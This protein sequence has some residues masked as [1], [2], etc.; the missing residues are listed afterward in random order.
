M[1]PPWPDHFLA[2]V[3]ELL[4]ESMSSHTKKMTEPG[5]CAFSAEKGRMGAT[6][7]DRYCPALSTTNGLHS[8]P[9]RHKPGIAG[10]KR[11]RG[12]WRN[13]DPSLVWLS[14][15]RERRT[16]MNTLRSMNFTGLGWSGLR[17]AW[18][19]RAWLQSMKLTWEEGHWT[20][21]SW[22]GFLRRTWQWLSGSVGISMTWKNQQHFKGAAQGEVMTSICKSPAEFGSKSCGEWSDFGVFFMSKVVTQ[23]FMHKTSTLPQFHSWGKH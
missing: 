8:P 3:V 2:L 18:L 15:G 16:E 14:D 10:R 11:Q 23:R 9:Y 21:W 19:P 1:A 17:W 12:A 22:T 7:C 5:A 13:V 6:Y 4:W 20:E